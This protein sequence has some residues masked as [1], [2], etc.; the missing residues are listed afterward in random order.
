[1]GQGPGALAWLAGDMDGDG[2]SDIFQAYNHQGS[3]GLIAYRSN[4]TGFSTAFASSNMRAAASWPVAWR[5]GDLDGDGL[6]DIF[7]T[8]PKEVPDVSREVGRNLGGK[9][10]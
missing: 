5:T 2:L 7:H 4:G 9:C 1:M 6:T 10:A 3:V 8:R